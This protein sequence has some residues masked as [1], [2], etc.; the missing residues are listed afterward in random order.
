VAGQ[1]EPA[2]SSSDSAFDTDKASVAA[3]IMNA[4]AQLGFDKI[5]S[6]ND[7]LITR[8]EWAQVQIMEAQARTLLSQRTA[9][10]MD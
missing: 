3:A 1:H 9:F 6:N 5:D 8:Q 2:S 10:T 4:A 7:G